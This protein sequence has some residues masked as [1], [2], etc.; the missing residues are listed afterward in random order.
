MP[1]NKS[2]VENSSSEDILWSYSDNMSLN[3]DLYLEDSKWTFLHH[4]LAH[5]NASP[6]Q[7][8]FDGILSH[9]THCPKVMSSLSVLSKCN[10]PLIPRA[11]NNHHWTNIHRSLHSCVTHTY[12]ATLTWFLGQVNRNTVLWC[13]AYLSIST[14]LTSIP[15]QVKKITVPSSVVPDTSVCKHNTHLNPRAGKQDLCQHQ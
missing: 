14:A 2:L 11:G 9:T 15:G 4:T 8:W 5:Y 13:L 1:S 12:Q 6:C 10:T 3:C 7:I